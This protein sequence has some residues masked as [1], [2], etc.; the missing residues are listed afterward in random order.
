MRRLM[1][2][3]HAKSDWPGMIADFDRP[4]APRGRQAAPAIGQYL[5]AQGLVP[6][7]SLVSP[8]RRTQETWGLVSEALG[9]DVPMRVEAGIYEAYPE[10][11]LALVRAAGPEVRS[12]LIVGHNPGLEELAAEL[13]GSGDAEQ[14]KRM[15]GKYP[16][17]ALAVIVFDGDD[18]ASVAPGEG[19]LDRFVTPASIGNGPDE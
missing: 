7:A 5:K 4:L 13:A 11:L 18:W 14:L 19:H 3:R 2:L 17:C 12:L 16:T 10:H 15:Q 9:A 6:D 8:A 1:L